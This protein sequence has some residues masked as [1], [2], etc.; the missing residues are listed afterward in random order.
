MIFITERK[1]DQYGR[2]GVKYGRIGNMDK[3]FFT[4]GQANLSVNQ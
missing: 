1:D 2:N 3:P 4:C